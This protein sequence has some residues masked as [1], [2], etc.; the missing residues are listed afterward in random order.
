MTQNQA[1]VTMRWW[2]G[3]L[4]TVSLCMLAGVVWAVR[5]EGRIDSCIKQHE[6]DILYIKEDISEIKETQHKILDKI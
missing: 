4:L 6:T 5:Q 1:Q 2:I 3:T